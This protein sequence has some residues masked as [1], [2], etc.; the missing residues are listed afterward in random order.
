MN[1]DLEQNG[2][3]EEA[4]HDDAGSTAAEPGAERNPDQI[5]SDV[6]DALRTV[7][8]P[9]VP[10]NIFDMGLIYEVDVEDDLSVYVKMTLTTPMCPVA[11]TLPP[12]VEEKARSVAGVTDVH[13]DLVWDPPW[14]PGMMSEVARLELNMM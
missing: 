12:E 14:H 8:D 3:G 9:E 2:P 5:K 10:V 13:L 7:Y 11:E 1:D 4:S 6:I